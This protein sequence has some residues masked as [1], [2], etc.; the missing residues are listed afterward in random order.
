MISLPARA[1][2]KRELLSGL[3]N[4]RP[5]LFLAMFL[6]V[7]ALGLL[8]VI[9]VNF[10]Q[11]LTRAGGIPPQTIR[12]LYMLLSMALYFGAVLLVPP[13]AGVSICIEKQQDSYDLL[14]MTYIRPISLA[15]AKLTNVLGLYLLVV[16]ATL[17]FVGVFFFLVGIEWRQVMVSFALILFSTTSLALLGLLC[18]AWCY[19]TL[20]AIMGTYFLGFLTHGGVLVGLLVMS[21]FFGRRSRLTRLLDGVGEDLLSALIPFIGLG[22]SSQGSTGMACVGYALAY[23]GAISL[24]AI[25]LTLA[26][27]RRPARTVNVNQETSIDDQVELKARRKRFPFYLLD[28]RRRRPL[29]PDGQNPVFAKELQTGFLSRGTFAIRVLYGATIFGFIV[30]LFAVGK[31]AFNRNPEVMP[32]WCFLIDTIFV[33]IIT[34]SLVATAMA[35]EWEWQNV[36]SLRTTLMRPREIIGG[37]FHAALRTAMLPVGGALIGSFPLVFFGYDSV[38]FWKMVGIG[39]AGMLLSVF[40]TL[41]LSFWSTVTSRHSLVALVTSYATVIVAIGLLPPIAKATVSAFSLHHQISRAEST[42]CNLLS[43]VYGLYAIANPDYRPPVENLIG[44]WWTSMLFFMGLSFLFI[45]LARHR[46][47]RNLYAENP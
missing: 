25:L 9:E 19:R 24:V 36:D 7:L 45:G 10:K 37:K 42:Y 46:Y 44:L 23:H 11:Q 34:P 39:L 22:V 1:V 4:P 40:Y 28:P 12:S 29:I 33:L 35:K 2:I 17:P 3:R 27:L 14:R 43:P 6:T 13:M 5:F 21:E 31:F 38:S 15:F 47:L 20:P 18:S 41:A 32:L 8:F 30:S 16:I 26:I